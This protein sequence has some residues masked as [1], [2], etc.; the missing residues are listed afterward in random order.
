LSKLIMLAK[1]GADADVPPTPRVLFKYTVA[2]LRPRAATSGYARP[3]ELN[4]DSPY[5]G[6]YLER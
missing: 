3:D 1:M 6:A 5:L 4:T 2:R